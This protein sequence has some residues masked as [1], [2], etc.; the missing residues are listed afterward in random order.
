MSPSRRGRGRGQGRE[1]GRRRSRGSRSTSR[2]HSVPSHRWSKIRIVTRA[3]ETQTREVAHTQAGRSGTRAKT[4]EGDGVET[5]CTITVVELF[6]LAFLW[7]VFFC[8]SRGSPW[9][10]W[11]QCG[12]GRAGAGC[13][14]SDGCEQGC[15]QVFVTKGE[16]SRVCSPFPAVLE[17]LQP[18]GHQKNT[19]AY[20]RTT[21][22]GPQTRAVAQRERHAAVAVDRLLVH[23][24]TSSPRQL[25]CL[26]RSALHTY[27]P[28][29]R[30]Q[31]SFH[32]C[33]SEIGP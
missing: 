32:F 24:G 21:R 5:C 28:T 23:S 8:F 31:S 26:D 20:E 11:L 2:S 3:R 17:I 12:P 10:L 7:F 6:F 15:F 9:C 27:C 29:V 18:D 25:F 4:R 30:S 19:R 14:G 13:G 33:T 22:G 16:R 1:G